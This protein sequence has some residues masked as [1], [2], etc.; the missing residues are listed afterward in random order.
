MNDHND[1]QD[2]SE[3]TP[4]LRG[5]GEASNGAG[6]DDTPVHAGKASA[7]PGAVPPKLKGRILSLLCAYAFAMMLADN[8][9][10]A[11]LTKVFEDVICDS[12]YDHSPQSQLSSEGENPCEAQPVQRELALVRGFLQLVPI[13]SGLLCTVPYGL[14][15][16]RV[17]RKRV[18]VLSGAGTLAAFA[19]VLAVCYWRFLPIRWVLLSGVFLFVGGGDPVL[20]SMLHVMVTDVTDQAER[21]QIFLYLHAADVVAGFFGPAV[22][23]PLMEKGHT[24]A[25]LLLAVAV[26]G[27][28]ITA[29]AVLVPETL[30]LKAVSMGRPGRVKNRAVS[31]SSSSEI[32]VL[33]PRSSLQSAIPRRKGGFALAGIE[34]SLAS[35]VAL[36]TS[37]RQATLLLC[38]YAPQ[39]ASR[40]LFTLIGLQYSSAKFALPYARGNVLLSLLQAAQGLVVLVV[41][42]LTT[43]LVANPRR[44]TAW[45]RDRLYA[46]ASIALL[47]AGLFVIGISPT[48]AVEVLGLLFV[49]LGSCSSGLLMSLLGAAVKPSQVSVVYSSALMLSIIARSLTGLVESALLIKGL[50]LGWAWMGLPFVAMGLFMACVGVA[51]VFVTAEK[52][53]LSDEE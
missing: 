33:S 35:L 46:T 49:A 32:V 43:R 10:P 8:L 23:A 9:Q 38:L 3:S 28:S 37:N 31:S 1:S 50:E 52:I 14:L 44:W 24:W 20:S 29:L 30:H 19:W 11:A 15:A 16:E 42:P 34:T 7:L 21:A 4:L 40:E 22:S 47:A 6:D 13:F 17:G 2:A 26:L 51:S 12:Y 39:T 25:V 45:A 53:E 36:L 48:L 27:T 5:R 41:L 18:L